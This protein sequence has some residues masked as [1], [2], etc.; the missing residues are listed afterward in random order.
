MRDLEQNKTV[1]VKK[2]V[3]G[4]VH[5][6]YEKLLPSVEEPK[7]EAFVVDSGRG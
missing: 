4:M 6:R 1:Y 3:V 5:S 2:E 7:P